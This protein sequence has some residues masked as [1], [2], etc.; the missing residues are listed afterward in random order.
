MVD[1]LKTIFWWGMAL[2][3]VSACVAFVSY[4]RLQRLS[5]G[6]KEGASNVQVAV[7]KKLALVNQLMDV[8]KGYLE[9]EQFTHL[10]IAQDTGSGGL[11]AAYQQSGTV[12][13]SLQG[14]AQR[15]PDLKASEQFHRLSE[16]ITTCEVSIQAQREQYNAAVKAYN[17]QCLSIPTVFVAKFLGFSS[18]PFLQFDH[19]GLA[20]VTALHEFKTDDGARLQNLLGGAGTQIAT[21]TKALA[22]HATQAGRQVAEM[23]KETAQAASQETLATYFH[24]VPPDGIPAGP[25]TLAEIGRLVRSGHLSST[26]LVAA[27]GSTEWRQFS[28]MDD[29]PTERTLTAL[30]P[31]PEKT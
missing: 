13:A 16:G 19:T 26:V 3:G 2:A 14:L 8:A 5:Q 20:D 30:T 25:A 6:V 18:A 12:L 4:N 27:A 17:S 28:E 29:T 31:P 23:I 7:S 24:R 1:L 15:Y 11:M 9:A 22:G 10:K 21:A